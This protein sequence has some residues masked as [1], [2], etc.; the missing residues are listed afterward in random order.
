MRLVGVSGKALTIVDTRNAMLVV[1]RELRN[2]QIHRLSTLRP[3]E[4][5]AYLP[6]NP[7]MEISLSAQMV[8]EEDLSKLRDPRTLKK[9]PREDFLRAVDWLI[10][11]QSHWG[12]SDVVIRAIWA[13]AGRIV[14]HHLHFRQ[15]ST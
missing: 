14:D 11:A 3:E 7:E 13:Y 15:A 5:I 10:D 6:V 9:Y 8:P 12:I 2:L 1:V 4:R